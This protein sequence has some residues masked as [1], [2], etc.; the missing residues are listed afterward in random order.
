MLGANVDS[1]S[2]GHDVLK[3]GF[4]EV[5]SFAEVTWA[6]TTVTQIL[7]HR[8]SAESA[9][10]CEIRRHYESDTYCYVYGLKRGGKLETA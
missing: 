3:V 10:S 9:V 1:N 7:V 2:V 6:R 8:L 5:D 4:V